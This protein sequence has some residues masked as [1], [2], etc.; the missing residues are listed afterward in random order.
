MSSYPPIVITH[1]GAFHADELMA[2][3][4][5]ERFAFT[6]PLR[7]ALCWEPQDV[8]ALIEHDRRPPVPAL[9]DE[10]GVQDCRQPVWVFRT[11][12]PEL[13][14]AARAR[15]DVFVIDVGGHYD[16]TALNFDH[17]QAEMTLTW[18]NGTTYSSTG[19]VWR[20]LE[21]TGRLS[22][23]PDQVRS[24]LAERLIEPLDAHDNGVRLSPDG[25]AV[26][27]Y[28]RSGGGDPEVQL[29][30][31]EKALR[32]CRDRLENALHATTN[33]ELARDVLAHAWS[34]ASARGE[35]FVILDE[36]L[37]GTDGT[38]LLHEVSGGHCLLLGLPSQSNRYSL[39]SLPA[40]EDRFSII[41][42]VPESWRGRMDFSVDLGQLGSVHLA[43]AHKTGFMCVVEGGP[44]ETRAVATYLTQSAAA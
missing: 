44:K 34:R 19:L 5:L 9:V 8:Q 38:R 37:P 14:E 29:I 24:S 18:P 26:E 3:A 43:F 31:F 12:Q 32:L 11:R 21:D 20:W 41:C 2:I 16:P 23:L 27:E 42:P 30:Q 15:P 6:S 10:R 35:R 28:N 39:I 22:S 4:L 13:L 17:H 25:T 36:P 40:N 33:R 1:A 7:V